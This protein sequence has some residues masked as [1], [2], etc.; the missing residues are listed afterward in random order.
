MTTFEVNF[1]GLIGPS[2]H[3]GGLS[4]GNLASVKHRHATS[5]PRKAALQGLAKMKHVADLGI[6]Q[7]FLP[8]QPR[9]DLDFLKAHG[10]SGSPSDM[11]SSAFQNR[12]DL[13]SISYS[14]SAMWTANA[15]T[16]SPSSDCDDK[17]VHITPAN[18][19]TMP[20]RALEVRHTLKVLKAIFG[21]ADH[22]TVHDPLPA[23]PETSDEGAAN[24]TRLCRNYDDP[25]VELFV[26][27]RD[28]H[29]S[30]MSPN[31]PA[32]QSL[33]A[34]EEIAGN[35][36]LNRSRIVLAQ[37]HPRAIDAGVF[38]NDVISVGNQSVHLVHQFAFA[39][40]DRVLADLEGCFGPG[41]QQIVIPDK[42]LEL[43]DAVQSYFFNSQLI[44]TSTSQMVL[45][46]PME[47]SENQA[48]NRL[49]TRL[50]QEDNPIY[51][52]QFVD[53]RESMQNGG[54]PACL[55]LRIVLSEEERAALPEGVFITEDRYRELCDWVQRHYRDHLSV[56]DLG[57]VNLIEEIRQAMQ[58]LNEMLDY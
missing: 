44:S 14:A 24:H 29:I 57:D 22:F 27:G 50:L 54:G 8:P 56:D 34:C 51:K 39:E 11:I 3:Y 37:Q 35:H 43:A 1:D 4:K 38:H 46:C 9:P 36:R 31:F 12:P 49:I 30:H 45:L 53:L 23:V 40:Q 55:R 18:L 5:S 52:C 10:F 48:A 17:R 20:H 58:E 2:H 7:A 16:V 33:T 41:L 15:A 25:G 32:R 6:P 26:F 19:Q 21:N 42:E 47:C 13:L 28:H